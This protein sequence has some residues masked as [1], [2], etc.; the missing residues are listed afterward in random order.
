MI[1]PREQREQMKKRITDRVVTRVHPLILT[2]ALI[3]S[4]TTISLGSFSAHADE[5]KEKAKSLFMKGVDLFSEE[6]LPEA[7]AAF[8][9]S[10]AMR[11][12]NSVLFNIGMC[13]KALF[14]YVE[15]IRTFR[16]YLKKGRG[17]IKSAQRKAAEEA[18]ARMEKLIGHL[19]VVEAPEGAEVTVD[20]VPVGTAPLLESLILDPGLH[21]VRVEKEG[22]ETLQTKVTIA[23]D[24]TIKLKAA[25]PL[26]KARLKIECKFDDDGDEQKDAF[27]YMDGEASGGCPYDD[28]VPAGRLEI[29]IKASGM[30]DFVTVV[31]VESGATMTIS[32]VLEP[33]ESEEPVLVVEERSRTLFISGIASLALGVGGGVV[34]GYFTYKGS[35]D[36]DDLV[37][38]AEAGDAPAYNNLKDDLGTD[39]ALMAVGYVSAGVFIVIG[40]VLL[41]VDAR[42]K[43]S[44]TTLDNATVRVAPA[45]GGLSLTF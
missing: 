45:R 32:A 17:K 41:M 7:L 39:K 4:V 42:R 1:E 9:E 44:E 14:N 18:L 11:P 3:V 38:A 36:H 26:K 37:R 19:E 21:S 23:S 28:E 27:V 5:A 43:D 24:A 15:S 31:E 10:Y 20:G 12:K 22:F 2:V 25:L 29:V 40:V 13:H 33:I 6:N 8:E 35:G 34:G 30:E 16:E